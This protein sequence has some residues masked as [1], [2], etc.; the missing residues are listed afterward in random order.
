VR[1]QARG[2]PAPRHGLV[3]VAAL[4]HTRLPREIERRL[5]AAAGRLRAVQAGAGQDLPPRTGAG[6][7]AA[8]LC[9][10]QLPPR[11]RSAQG[12]FGRFSTVCQQQAAWGGRHPVFVG[13]GVS[14]LCIM[15]SAGS[16]HDTEKR[17]PL[18]PLPPVRPGRR[19]AALLGA[20]ARPPHG[21]GGG[22]G[23]AARRAP[24]QAP[25]LLPSSGRPGG[26]PERRL[27][28][29]LLSREGVCAAARAP[30]LSVPHARVCLLSVPA[31]LV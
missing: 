29:Q 12:A 11:G 31:C 16:D 10:A 23:A 4:P 13:T 19:D 14:S 17:Q 26:Y 15:H 1:N 30:S 18:S 9:G 20:A 2:E 28:P 24:S 27:L 21:L 3:R 25:A 7:L 22:G 6:G 5:L 8:A